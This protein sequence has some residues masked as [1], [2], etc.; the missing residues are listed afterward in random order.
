MADISRIEK[1]L[2]Q[3][4]S[5][6]NW[7]RYNHFDQVKTTKA[8]ASFALGFP[9]SALF[10]IYRTIADI[11]I[12]NIS[13][14]EALKS[15]SL[16]KDPLT[17]KLGKEIVTAFSAYNR[18]QKLDGLEIFEGAVGLFKV[19]RDISVPVKPTFVIL[20]NGK[21][22]PVFVI[23]WTSL[24]FST[25]QKRLLTTVIEDALLSLSDFSGSDAVVICA[26]R[27]G[28]SQRGIVSWLT[29]EF[30]RLNRDELAQQLER[31]TTGL[32]EAL[33]I[34]KEELARRALLQKPPVG[35]AKKA[36]SNDPNQPGLF[37]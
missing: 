28:K 29:S 19:S 8:I 3:P 2:K 7:V 12:W 30:P 13:D 31:Y 20:K 4:P 5:A 21:P 35:V 22:T 36:P 9:R 34:V 14:E 37:D 17:A 18:E 25:H 16:I 32:S 10:Q 27:V 11:V 15:V 6:P 23:G 24:P 1:K 26:P 33:P